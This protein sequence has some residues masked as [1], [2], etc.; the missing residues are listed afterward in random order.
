MIVNMHIFFEMAI[1]ALYA[2]IGAMTIMIAYKESRP[3][4]DPVVNL[5]QY[6]IIWIALML[7][8]INN[9]STFIGGF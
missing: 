1:F 6:V 5:W 9:L 7:S 3:P 4:L 2:V 8:C